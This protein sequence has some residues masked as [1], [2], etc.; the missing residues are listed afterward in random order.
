MENIKITVLRLGHR[1]ERDKRITTHVAL[2]ARAFGAN[3]IQ[4][5]EKDE[6]IEKT[7]RDVVDRF[8]GDFS[9]RTGVNWKRL[10]R[11]WD[12]P[13]VHLTMYGESLERA[14][15]NIPEGHV[16][17]VVGAEKV[18]ADVYKLADTNLSVGNQPH[19]EVAALALFLDR[20]TAAGWTRHRFEGRRTI[21]PSKKGKIVIDMEEGYLSREDCLEILKEAGCE[22][23]V[24]KH[25]EVVTKL[26]VKM[27]GI[28]EADVDLVRTS[29]MLHDIGR[30]VTHGPEH[31]F[32]GGRILRELGFP[33]RIAFIV[34]RHVGGGLDAREL[35]EL[36]LPA[37][38]L[39]PVTLEEKIVCLAD[40]LVD[41][42]QKVR[43]EIEIQKL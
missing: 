24:V 25:S 17:A 6:E 19:S 29:S 20:L 31:G 42:N 13:V 8:G 30:S 34:E 27:A 35:K 36:G 37:K 11:Q 40:K 23:N 15:G 7:I 1:P 32:E 10:I 2:V 16:L 26:A 18:P 5:S 22:D 21:I 43:L 3:S 28:C 38:D 9:I 4:I 39:V 14:I 41:D 12:G 33:G